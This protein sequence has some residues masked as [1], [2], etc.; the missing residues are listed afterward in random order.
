MENRKIG[1][2]GGTGSRS[3][4]GTEPTHGGPG[5]FY[6]LGNTV[7][8]GTGLNLQLR[9]ASDLGTGW[10]RAQLAYFVGSPSATAL[11][12]ATVIFL[13]SGEVYHPAWQ[14]GTGPGPSLTGK[15]EDV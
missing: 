12:V 8:L 2:A 9:T 1:L 7:A 14:A 15:N 3:S 11:A 10:T 13:V 6:S 5:G 4:P